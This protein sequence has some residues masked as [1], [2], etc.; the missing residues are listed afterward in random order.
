MK[1]SHLYSNRKHYEAYDHVLHRTAIAGKCWLELCGIEKAVRIVDQILEEHVCSRQDWV[2]FLNDQEW[3]VQALFY[4]S[5][6]LVRHRAMSL[7]EAQ[8]YSS[9]YQRLRAV[10][11][12]EVRSTVTVDTLEE[13]VYEKP[14]SSENWKVAHDIA[15]TRTDHKEEVDRFRSHCRHS[16]IDC[17]L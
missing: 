3:N 2:A 8:H 6:Q 13:L 1:I 9:E 5:P 15:P 7:L 10:S 12:S 4:M 14:C 11:E 17:E 16:K